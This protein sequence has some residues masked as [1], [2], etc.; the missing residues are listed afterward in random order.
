MRPLWRLAI[1]NWSASP[2]RALAAVVAVAL[3]VGIVVTLASFHET[4]RRLI[5]H[6]VA[7]NW[8]GSADLS[9][10][11]IGAHWG[12][13][14]T[15]IVEALRK[16]DNVEIVS[17]R[18]K[19]RL[20]VT[21]VIAQRASEAFE[22]QRMDALGLD[23]ASAAQMHAAPGLVGRMLGPGDRDVALI[24]KETAEAWGVGLGDRIEV[25]SLEGDLRR[26]LI[27]IGLFDSTRV[28]GFQLPYLYLPLPDHQEIVEQP[29]RATAIDIVLADN[30]PAAIARAREAFER[31]IDEA[32][33]AHRYRVDTLDA[34]QTL[35]GGANK[36]MRLSLILAAIVALL[37]A[38]F[39]I[40]TTMSIALYERR[41]ALGIMRCLGLSRGQLAGLLVFEL[42]PL[43]VIGTALGVAGGFCTN[44]LIESLIDYTGIDLQ[45]TGWQ[46]E[47]AIGG[48]LMTTVVVIVLLWFQVGR[49]SPLAA[50]HTEAKPVRRSL[51]W[52]AGAAGAMLLVMHEY[53]VRVP[54]QLLWLNTAYA[55]AGTAAI[56]LGYG[57]LTPALVQLIGPVAARVFGPMLGIPAKLAL[58]QFGRSPWRST[59]VCW[60]LMV[61]L[62]LM[63][64]VIVASNT[65]MN[66]WNFPGELPGAFVWARQFVPAERI[67]EIEGFPGVENLTAVVDVDCEFLKEDDRAFSLTDNV[68]GK[69]LTSITRP[70]FVGGDVE[71]LMRMVKV[72]FVEGDRAEALRRI[73]SGG[74]VLVPR[75]TALNKSLHLGDRVTIGINDRQAQFEIAGIVE[76]PVLDLTVTFFQMR[77]TLQFA[78][79]AVV[80]GNRQDL[81]EKFDLDVF[82]MVMCDMSLPPV[83][84][85]DVFGRDAP[86]KPGSREDTVHFVS[87]IQASLDQEVG[88]AGE[89]FQQLVDRTHR[90]L[91]YMRWIWDEESPEGRW[92]IFRE[93]LMLE[94]IAETMGRP[95][96]PKGS[97]SRMKEFNERILRRGI[98]ALTW[99][100]AIVLIGAAIGIANLIMVSVQ[101]RARQI[102]VLRAVGGLKSQIIR[103]VLAEA[104]S[105]GFVGS[106]VGVALGLHQTY[107][108][109]R[110]VGALIGI[111]PDLAFPVV[112][113]LQAMAVTTLVCLIAGLW[114]AWKASRSDIAGTLQ[115]TA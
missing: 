74:H 53:L 85:P 90:T 71:R 44:A 63:I 45:V 32:G 22:V 7:V 5:E 54:E 13:L 70:V 112:D 10:H 34:R 103:L 67:E 14:D 24:E 75:Q 87:D 17:P 29:G 76:A 100:P 109:N 58:D 72:K 4:T 49:T 2:G 108:D 59:G 91:R 73:K 48:G 62:S 3:G 89:E 40:L 18:L 41:P 46:L 107:T 98:A 82:S 12:A 61:G 31:V 57:L 105:L 55:T 9:I 93:R 33:H 111:Q 64:Y 113:L 30:A 47:L 42:L 79:A 95:E 78:A 43:G 77:S 94:R 21:R 110:V 86:P 39:I 25:R 83:P 16:V 96:A 6:E 68:V 50:V 26:E 114:P 20:Y 27:L 69:F 11:P 81:V 8:L 84:P 101:I 1:R 99:L 115:T 38:F 56:F 65:V 60:M 102:A 36:I 66:V 88:I 35:M 51:I 23:P 106:V 19:R 92:D 80:L 97:L 52:A 37:S 28:A 104:A 15:S